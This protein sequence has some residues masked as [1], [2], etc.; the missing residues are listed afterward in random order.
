MRKAHTIEETLATLANTRNGRSFVDNFGRNVE[1]VGD[2]DVS[3][4]TGYNNI[5]P[6]SQFVRLIRD[7]YQYG[8]YLIPV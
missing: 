1:R 7:G 5:I 8:K 4:G 6:V 2:T 3:V